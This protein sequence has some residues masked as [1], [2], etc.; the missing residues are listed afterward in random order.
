MLESHTYDFAFVAHQTT[1]EI[2]FIIKAHNLDTLCDRL[3]DFTKRIANE[4]NEYFKPRGSE[5][6]LFE[7]QLFENV[8]GY[9]N[10]GY[11][12]IHDDEAWLRIRLGRDWRIYEATYTIHVLS[13]IL[14]S[15]FSTEPSNL[16]QQ[17]ELHARADRT[18]PGWG[19]MLG[20][21]VS[22]SVLR[23][24]REYAEKNVAWEGQ[25]WC[26]PM[27]PE[28]L[29]AMRN[30]WQAMSRRELL[31]Y[32]NEA[33]GVISAE[34]RFILQCFGNAC[35]I[36]IYPDITIYEEE[37]YA[38]FSCHNLDSA[39]QQL[40]LLTGLIKILELARQSE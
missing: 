24:L 10:C 37:G 18:A 30:T 9:G 34:G 27:H 7:Q 25:Y 33:N 6:I 28:V 5:F 15:P 32:A 19:H 1:P 31:Q 3:D 4:A 22:A 20:G 39:D 36:A 17:V 38:Q 11:V 29:T 13:R 16:E 8:F 2:V 40:T 14:M 26:T 23:W 21:H 12:T 35:D